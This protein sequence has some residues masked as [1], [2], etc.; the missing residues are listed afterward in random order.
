[1]YRKRLLLVVILASAGI[2]SLAAGAAPEIPPPQLTLDLPEVSYISPG[3]RDG[4]QDRIEWSVTIEA[5]ERMVVKGYRVVLTDENGSEAYL[6]EVTFP[7]EQ[8][9]FQRLFIGLGF[10]GLKAAVEVPESLS[11]DGELTDGSA[12]PEGAYRLVVEGWDDQDRSNASGEHIVVVD[13][14]PPAASVSLPYEIYSPNGDGNKDILIIEQTGSDES[15]WSGVF[16]NED[17]STMYETGWEDGPPQNFTWDGVSTDGSVAIDGFYRYLLV[18]TDL[19]GNSFE[20][21]I[22]SVIIDTKDPP[23]SVT[24]DSGFFSPNADGVGDSMRLQ[25]DVPVTDGIRVWR[26]EIIDR[27]NIVRRTIIGETVPA[28]IEYDGTDDNG[29]VLPEGR[30]RG[31][32]AVLYING[33]SPDA[34]S[35]EFVLD[36]TPPEVSV[37]VDSLVF[38]P[39]GDGEID[40]IQVYQETSV[41]EEWI[42]EVIDSRANVIREIGWRGEAERMV[43][44]EGRN[45]TN[46]LVADGIY[47]YRLRSRDRAGNYAEAVSDAFTIDTRET[48]IFLRSDTTY[49]SPNGDGVQDEV[50]FLPELVDPVGFD[51]LTLT[52]ADANGQSVRE[53]T[54]NIFEPSLRW[55]GLNGTGDAAPDG[56]YYALLRVAYVHG[57]KPVA[58][59]GPVY[60]DRD[61]PT[62]EVSA[63]VLIFSP[64]GDGRLDGVQI[65]QTEASEEPS[66]TGRFIDTDESV[67]RS[68]QWSGRAQNFV[69]DGTDDEGNVL[70]DGEYRYE[71]RSAD[72]SGNE[73]RFEIAS[74]TIDTRPTPVALR[75]GSSAFSPDGNGSQDTV[76]IVPLLEVTDGVE[77]WTLEILDG[78]DQVRRTLSGVNEVPESILYDG[79]DEVGAVLREGIFTARLSLVYQSG[80]RPAATSAPFTVDVTVPWANVRPRIDLFSPNGD[81]RRDSVLIE[82]D[83][84]EETLWSGS[85]EDPDGTPI[86]SLSWFGSLG[87]IFEWD[88]R[89]D[90]GTVV[91]NGRYL[92]RVHATDRAGNNGGS[93]EISI[94]VDNR[95][96][97]VALII[98]PPF[99]SPN[100]DDILDRVVVTPLLGIPEG[101]ESH[102]LEIQDE[103]G[104]TVQIIDG[105]RVP[106]TFSWNGRNR[107]GEI[108]PD[109]PYVAHLTLVYTKGDV[110]DAKS[111]VFVIDTTAPE[112]RATASI[113]LFSPEGDSRKDIVNIAQ[114]TS[115]EDL[116][117]ATIYDERDRPIRTDMF[118]KGRAEDV[119]WDGRDDEGSIASDGDYRYEIAATDRAG[120]RG[121]ATI[122]PIRIDTRLPS[123]FMS[124]SSTAIAPNGDGANETVS[125]NIYPSIE[126]GIETWRFAMLDSSGRVARDLTSANRREIP[127]TIVWDGRDSNGVVVQGNFTPHLR[128]EYEKGNLVEVETIR[129]ILVDTKGP[130][131]T[132]QMVPTPFSPDGDGENDTLR[133]AFRRVTDASRIAAWSVEIVDPRGNPFFE[134]SGTG[135]PPASFQW[136]GVSLD[137]ELVQAA[138]DYTIH[139]TATDSLA[140][141]GAYDAV[142]PVDI[143]VLKDGNNLKIRIS[144]IQFAPNSADF[145]EFDEE[146]S[147]R[148]RRTLTRLAEILEKYAEYQIR[149]EGHAVSVFWDDPARAAVEEREELQPLSEARAAAV[150]EA[151]T[152]LGIPAE[153]MTTEGMGGTRP[154][155]PHGDVE[156]RWKSRRV[157]FILIR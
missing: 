19:A 31:K 34:E 60:L 51:N 3:L 29:E 7:G 144:S 93:G 126:D 140:N 96:A 64:D 41:E 48:P 10:A 53:F 5:S 2:V 82:Q 121:S 155:V 24:K 81:G 76:E 83:G 105:I 128:V 4:T 58:R 110:P 14:T 26:F 71:L 1:M 114:S 39:N 104:T 40:T 68:L 27:Q 137:G 138:E 132:L 55:D 28:A 147:E 150:K 80:S 45:D 133:I 57:N 20:L 101:I 136:D 145:L 94:S 30:Y 52:V 154:V 62:A 54:S 118:W 92:Y 21:A 63:S 91:P 119:T 102:I 67:V 61:S 86:R 141:V 103:S 100:D 120:N 16:L 139:G 73:G 38:S 131:F 23:I 135:S 25:F 99:F 98:D 87:S 44:W 88:G 59:I 115:E 116:W 146:K 9:F 123:A 152:E 11:W 32:L 65:V 90:A 56:A 8:P 148:N 89:D 124:S 109:G 17:D 70:P 75:I 149:I 106:E 15:L 42:G 35:S 72:R 127:D 125:V 112:A 6:H 18:A 47:R 97:T 49:A 95:N 108:A 157:E 33:N 134:R 13:N 79:R 84:S 151:L 153:R 142:L 78:I 69:W 37:R 113:T 130:T 85:L 77:N 111:Q 50:V 156:N 66:W 12:A 117:E 46:N 107:R 74:L 43:V 22:D 122:R 143:L 129:P 36:V